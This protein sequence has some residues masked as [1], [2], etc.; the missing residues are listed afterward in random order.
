MAT[1]KINQFRT[2]Q[3]GGVSPF[4]NVTSLLFVLATLANGSVSN[5][6]SAV[7]LAAGDV[8][9]LGPLPEGMRLEDASVFVTTGM[10]A[11]ITGSLGF[12]YEDG[13]DDAAVPQD[14]AYFGSGID[15]AAAGRKRATGSKL[16]RL[17]KPARLILTTAVAANAKASDVKVIV[18]G[19][20]TGP[21]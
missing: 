17:P 16:V 1:V 5:S 20:L 10:T 12:K 6:D 3:F 14:A 8:V 2:R 11:T 9:D 21:A 4:G 18:Q 19:E 15:L 7:A 13:V